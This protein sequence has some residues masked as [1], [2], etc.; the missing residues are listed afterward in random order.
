[1]DQ[2]VSNAM[3]R[4][5]LYA[6]LL[7]LFAGVAMMLAA[8][9]IYGVLSYLVT[10]RAREIGIRMALGAQQRQVVSLVLRQTAVLTVAGVV[11]GVAGAAALSRYLEGLLFGLT[12]LD[13]GTFVT[14][15]MLFAATAALA[16]FVPARRATRID[17][18]IALRTE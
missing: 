13:A 3:S 18:L 14:V 6:V 15:V 17:P 8:I 1:M 12:P 5:R 11:I 10:Q 9:G 7:G 16:S 4:P 2:I